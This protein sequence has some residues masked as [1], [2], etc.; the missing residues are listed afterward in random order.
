M[1]LDLRYNR[2]QAI[3]EASLQCPTPKGIVRTIGDRRTFRCEIYW[4]EG[5]PQIQW[6]LPNN[7]SLLITSVSFQEERIVYFGDLNF[8]T[9]FYLNPEGFT[10]CNFTALNDSRLKNN[11]FN[12]VGKTVSSLTVSPIVLQTWNGE[13]VSCSSLFG[14]ITAHFNVTVFSPSLNT[15][16]NVISTI[17][18]T[19]NSQKETQRTNNNSI[20]HILDAEVNTNVTINYWDLVIA[21]LLSSSVVALSCFLIAAL[22]K[23]KFKLWRVNPDSCDVQD[24]QNPDP[25]SQHTY[26]TVRDE[27]QYEVVPDSQVEAD[28]AITPYGQSAIAGAYRMDTP[29]AATA[30]TSHVTKHRR[31][32]TPCV[33]RKRS[34]GRVP[35]DDKGADVAESSYNLEASRRANVGVGTRGVQDQEGTSKA[36]SNAEIH[37]VQVN[38][39]RSDRDLTNANDSYQTSITAED[40]V[41]LFRESARTTWL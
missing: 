33:M 1:L 29:M 18:S 10:C 34:Q 31:V 37:D 6:T 4:E 17:S 2:I 9:S 19:T 25:F 13:L 24:Q 20:I 36:Y 27:D 14:N 7:T 15:G 35:R 30:R 39:G 11:T 22:R 26:E 12:F 40:D 3:D 21:T 28:D 16:P 32:D 23:G 5:P 41:D 8:T 38:N